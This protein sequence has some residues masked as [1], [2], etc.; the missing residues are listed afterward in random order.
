[1]FTFIIPSVRKSTLEYAVD[2]VLAQ[3]YPHWNA[4]V[5][6]DGV[7]V[8]PFEDD[9]ILTIIAPHRQDASKTRMYA[10]KYAVTP[11]I[12]FLDDDDWVEPWYLTSF[13]PYLENSDVVISKMNNYG[14]EIPREHELIHGSVGISFTIRTEVLLANPFPPPP[15]EDYAILVALKDRG[16]RLSYTDTCGY[17]VRKYQFDP[18]FISN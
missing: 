16:Y 9:R 14:W 5:C 2:S 3:E 4:I 17:Y 12:V 10:A 8:P 13:L 7:Y 18:N 1:M 11:W 15:S 6:G